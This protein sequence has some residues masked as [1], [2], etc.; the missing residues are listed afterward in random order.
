MKMLSKIAAKLDVPKLEHLACHLGI[1]SYD[2]IKA[3]NHHSFERSMGVLKEWYDM[4]K[5][6]IS[7]LHLALQETGHHKAARL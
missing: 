2:A 1:D 3:D 5:G 6:D 7:D 4:G